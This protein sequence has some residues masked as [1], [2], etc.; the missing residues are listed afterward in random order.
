MLSVDCFS[1][2]PSHWKSKAHYS[3][4]RTR[5]PRKVIERFQFP[6]FILH[7]ERQLENIRFVTVSD[8]MTHVYVTVGRP[9]SPRKQSGACVLG[10]GHTRACRTLAGPTWAQWRLC[11]R[12]FEN[13]FL[14]RRGVCCRPRRGSG[15]SHCIQITKWVECAVGQRV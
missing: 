10:T 11:G 8:L 15:L 7:L 4:H 3:A 2:F 1:S 12:T 9:S 6:L 13:G 5:G 14:M